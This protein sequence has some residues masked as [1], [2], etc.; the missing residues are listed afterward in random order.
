MVH[1]LDHWQRCFPVLALIT[2]LRLVFIEAD[3][4]EIDLVGLVASKYPSV[5]VAASTTTNVEVTLDLLGRVGLQSSEEEI[6]SYR[7]CLPYRAFLI[8]C[9]MQFF[10][11]DLRSQTLFTVLHFGVL[12]QGHF[13]GVSGKRLSFFSDYLPLVVEHA[14][15]ARK[16]THFVKWIFHK[17][18]LAFH[19]IVFSSALYFDGGGRGDGSMCISQNPR[20]VI[21]FTLFLSFLLVDDA[22]N[23]RFLSFDL[24]RAIS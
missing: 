3:A 12:M 7:R 10:L 5:I 8:C 24:A 21:L 17:F 19:Y 13:G 9:L 18:L 14:D 15:A 6:I 1:S 23:L 2:I 16:L 22:T 4:A 11:A 20:L